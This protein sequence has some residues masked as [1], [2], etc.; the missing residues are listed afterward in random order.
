[1]ASRTTLSWV[2]PEQIQACR[3]DAHRNRCE[4]EAAHAVCNGEANR[5]VSKPAN[6]TATTTW[7]I[8]PCLY[9]ALS[10]FNSSLDACWATANPG[11]HL[12][13]SLNKWADDSC[14][15]R[16]ATARPKAGCSSNVANKLMNGTCKTRQSAV[17][18]AD[19]YQNACAE[20]A[21]LPYSAAPRIAPAETSCMR[22]E[23]SSSKMKTSPLALL[24]WWRGSLRPSSGFLARSSSTVPC[25]T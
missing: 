8:C 15:S 10:T 14:P 19:V 18:F 11:R 23:L 7:A 22:I 9:H 2:C 16:I 3:N 21:A 12:L 24:R 25:T 5:N 4:S 13:A 20:P 6:Q 17:A 1:M